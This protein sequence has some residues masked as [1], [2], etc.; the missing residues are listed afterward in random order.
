MAIANCA[1]E[2]A[3]RFH[4]SRDGRFRRPRHLVAQTT[5]QRRCP[6]LRLAVARPKTDASKFVMALQAALSLE[7]SLGHGPRPGRIAPRN[8][9]APLNKLDFGIVNAHN[10]ASR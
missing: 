7:P 6:D 1:G 10:Q 5:S 4:D 3:A 9:V 8:D 2:S